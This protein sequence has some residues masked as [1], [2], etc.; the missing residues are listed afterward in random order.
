MPEHLAFT[1]LWTLRVS[2]AVCGSVRIALLNR[3]GVLPTSQPHRNV[4]G[5]AGD[6]SR[7]LQA[8]QF[9]RI[10]RPGFG[11]P[12]NTYP[13]SMLWWRGKLYVGTNRAFTCVEYFHLHTALPNVQRYPP[14]FD[15]DVRC[16]QS[17]YDLPLQAE[18]WCYTPESGAWEC[19]HQSPNDVAVPDEPGRLTA[20]DIG[21]RGMLA[22]TEADGTEALY[23]AGVSP[24]ALD[25][26][27]PG[28]RLLRSTDGY[29]FS[30]VPSDPGTVLGDLP[31]LGFRSMAN[32]KGRLY[33]TSG[34]LFGDGVL[35]ESD[36]PASGNDAFRL[37]LPSGVRV[38]EVVSFNGFLY[39]G[40]RH[41]IKGYAIARIDASG[42]PPY[43]LTTVVPYG[44]FRRAL[45][46][47]SVIHMHVFKGCLYAA[48]DGPAEVVRVYPDD[49]WDLVVG[50]PRRTPVGRKYPLS[51]LGDGFGDP[52][53][54]E[55]VRMQEHEGWMYIGTSKYAGKLRNWPL[56]GFLLES[57]FGFDLFATNDGTR[58]ESISRSGLDDATSFSIR[59][60]ASTP[61]GLF[62]GVNNERVGAIIYLAERRPHKT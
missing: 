51:G 17:P 12:W 6:S 57:H 35:L 20:R 31:T 37:V 45:R 55:I 53:A 34:N 39:L 27:L 42:K 24:R 58:F 38:N 8:S 36:N 15:P 14:R 62:L 29:T 41:R 2:L 50:E 1:L 26:R 11:D 23:V 59:T 47:T 32:H 18:I 7:L 48:T 30:P 43:A 60:F 3:L 19:V 40:L 9:A 56:V 46:A 33:V 4:R 22:Y 52:L 25:R 54:F 10:N 49:Q 5:R 13:W 16:P 28:P 21:Y 44:A 61:P